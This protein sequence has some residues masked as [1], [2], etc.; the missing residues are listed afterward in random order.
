MPK[1]MTD[2]ACEVKV[3]A[4]H[5]FNVEHWTL[6]IATRSNT[7]RNVKLRPRLFLFFLPFSIQAR[8]RVH[9]A[10]SPIKHESA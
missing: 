8:A 1:L 4:L 7:L 2:V 6:T 10:C 3:S 9:K 5:C